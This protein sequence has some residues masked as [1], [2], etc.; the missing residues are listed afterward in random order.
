MCV[1]ATFTAYVLSESSVLPLHGSADRFGPVIGQ[2]KSTS[3]VVFLLSDGE[4]REYD[5]V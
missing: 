1:P 4:M 5:I 3:R 2:R